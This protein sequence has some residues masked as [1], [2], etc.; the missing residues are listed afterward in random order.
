MVALPVEEPV[1]EDAE[2]ELVTVV[3]VDPDTTEDEA[4][5]VPPAITN[6][7]L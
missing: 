7:R 4:L 3:V 1:D 2:P 6:W 5:P